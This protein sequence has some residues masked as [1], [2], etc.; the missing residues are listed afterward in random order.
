MMTDKDLASIIDME[1]DILTH[2]EDDLEYLSDIFEGEKFSQAEIEDINKAL[3]IILSNE[4]LSP[5]RKIDYTEN[6][7]KVNFFR[8][9]PKPEEYLTEE[10][11]GETANSLYPHIRNS[12]I[13]FFDPTKPYRNLVEYYPIGSGKSVLV[14][15]I[16]GYIAVIDYYLRDKKQFFKL[17]PTTMI[18]DAT[19]SLSLDMAYDLNI[20]PMLNYMETSPKFARV[21]QESQLIKKV[22]EDKDT[23][24]FT[25]ATK[26]GSILRIGDL[27]YRTISEPSQL[28]GLTIQMVSLTE[29]GFLQ[30]K[31]MKPETVM[32]LLND[33]KGRIY[34][35]FGNHYFARSVIDSSPNDLNN[36]VDRYIMYESIKDPSVLRLM[37]QKWNLQPHLFPIYEKTQ[38]TFPMYKGN[39]S[40]EPRI[41]ESHE[42]QNFDVN[43]IFNVPIDIKQLAIDSPVKVV[44]DYCGWPSGSDSKLI[45]NADLIEKIF[46][47]HLRNFYTFKHAP[48]DLPPEG[49]LWDIVKKE[50]FLYSGQG[51][52]Y[53][54]YR[55]P[56]A[57]RFISIDLAKKYDMATISMSHLEKNLKNE[58]VY[59]VDFSLAILS[60]KVEINLD[61]FKFLILDMQRYGNINI[62]K[63]SF[64]QFQSD[65]SRQFL[66]RHGIDAIRYSVDISTEPY[67]SFIS[68]A[69][70]DRIKMGRNLVMKNNLKSLINTKSQSG[71]SKIDHEQGDWIDLQNENWDTSRMGYYGK[72]LSD[73]VVA[74]CIL[75][76]LYGTDSSDFVFDLDKEK[77]KVNSAVDMALDEIKAKFNL[78]V[79]NNLLARIKSL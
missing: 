47:P 9:P 18:C 70:Q 24:Y 35:R 17:A 51:Q 54:F 31:G 62:K 59:V 46:T 21:K 16:K 45:T 36:P 11:I 63:V 7:W 8:R 64:D 78:K 5:E 55:L 69:S 50:L 58:K 23:V 38:E 20:V 1:R 6:L 76:D 66:I 12:F 72:D 79:N 34:S 13:D 14:A 26:G 28:L 56:K 15:L 25:T 43:D 33:S 49:L 52:M 29:L 3:K 77:E 57:E 42:L 10:W 30:E 32:R 39:S 4:A 61:A 71:K 67:L 19:V 22:R 73:S 60:T 2:P 48:A 40:K 68:Y 41:V 53:D 27:F 65:S 44:K 74:S 37:G 75:A